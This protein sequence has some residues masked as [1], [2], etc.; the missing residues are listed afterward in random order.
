MS[1]GSER[2]PCYVTDATLEERWR[3][4]FERAPEAGQEALRA[5]EEATP[6]RYRV[7]GGLLVRVDPE[8]GQTDAPGA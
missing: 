1:K 4:A 3:R 8:C 5:P 2:R 7:S 6:V